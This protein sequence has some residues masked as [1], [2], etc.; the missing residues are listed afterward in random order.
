M[1]TWT[2][3]KEL[4]GSPTI[5]KIVDWGGGDYDNFN[6]L[7]GKSWDSKRNTLGS[8]TG[9][10]KS[11][12]TRILWLTLNELYRSRCRPYSS[13]LWWWYSPCWSGCFR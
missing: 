4:R 8:F 3:V 10:A 1:G 12:V 7:R 2:H 11:S 5:T 6:S 13:C 9:M